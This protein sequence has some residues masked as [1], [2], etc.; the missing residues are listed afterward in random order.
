[1][2]Q[3]ISKKMLTVT[4][5]DSIIKLNKSQSATA[6][7]VMDLSRGNARQWLMEYRGDRTHQ[8][9]ADMAGISRSF[10]TEIET[11]EKDPSVTTAK[12]IGRVLG[13]DWTIFF[14]EDGRI[15]ELPTGT[16]Q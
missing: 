6:K 10:Y 16:D 4:K 8:V 12:S 7:E 2:S 3:K 9:I 11:G 1:M 5:C 15:M 13:F 14:E